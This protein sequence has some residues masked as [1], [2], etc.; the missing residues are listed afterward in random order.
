MSIEDIYIRKFSD[1]HEK[2]VEFIARCLPQAIANLPIKNTMKSARALPEIVDTNLAAVI[3]ASGPSLTD[4]LPL[5]RR[6]RKRITLYCVDTA[7]PILARAGVWP[8]VVVTLDPEGEL[9]VPS[10][11]IVPPPN[12]SVTL[13]LP[14][15]AHSA[16]TGA[17]QGPKMW[18]NVI[19]YDVQVYK[20][21]AGYFHEIIGFMAKPNVAQFMVNIA[22]VLG[23]PALAWAGMDHASKIDRNYA[24]GAVVPGSSVRREDIEILT[25]DQ[26]LRPVRTSGSYVLMAEAFI[27]HYVNFYHER[28]CFNLSN[29]I[30]PFKRNIKEFERFLERMVQNA[31]SKSV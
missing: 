1:R 9:L 19:A 21:I 29:G 7:Y 26:S 28:H 8:D 3:A 10:L 27:Y 25:V 12:V 20:Q 31:T 23:H 24:E 15:Y 6:N 30:L 4:T 11:S 2:T 16:V 13:L 5:I 14:T 18:F 17:W 22:F